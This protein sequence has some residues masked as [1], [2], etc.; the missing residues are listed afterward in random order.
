MQS[1][2]QVNM[3]WGGFGSLLGCGGKIDFLYLVFP[4]VPN[5]FLYGVPNSNSHRK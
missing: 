4:D 5:V 2:S 1:M 3:Q